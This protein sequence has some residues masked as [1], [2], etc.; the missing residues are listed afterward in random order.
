MVNEKNVDPDNIA[1]YCDLK[2]DNAFPPP[3]NFHLFSGGDNDYDNFISGEFQHVI[4]NLTLQEGWDDPCCYFAYI[5]KDMSSKDQITQIVGRVLRQPGVQHYGHVDLNTAHFYIRTDDKHVF[6]QV[7]DDVKTKISEETPEVTLT[8]Y[9]GKSSDKNS[10]KVTPRKSMKLPYVT[11]NC[12]NAVEPI[13][14]IVDLI[15][16]YRSDMQGNTVGVGSKI[17]VLQTIASNNVSQDQWIQLEHTNK[18]TARFVFKRE[19][20]KY[21]RKLENLC[22]T[23]EPKFDA[24]IEYYSRAA[25]NIIKSAHDVVKAYVD[26]SVVTQNPNHN[27]TVSEIYIDPHKEK[28]FKHSL[29]P[30]YSDFNG[31]ELDFANALDET[32][33]IWLRNPKSGCFSIPLL[34]VGDTNN[35]VPDFV[36]WTKKSIYAI[37]TK[38]A[39]LI[40]KDSTRKLLDVEKLGKGA[41]L[42]IRLVTEGEWN[43]QYNQIG[44]DGYTVWKLKNGKIQPFYTLTLKDC[45]HLCIIP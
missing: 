21:Y 9:K 19:L 44:K 5:D 38:G 4:F 28:T 6:E 12:E 41:D 20:Q 1:V 23:E 43:Q 10:N 8:V 25:E 15:T 22:P 40:A 34:D 13:M 32:K 24:L 37:D 27:M 11:V 26:Y 16:D 35:F 18:I 3:I 45:I 39:H 17:K 2:F 33:N 36:V 30:K 31:L 42:Y 29:H 7:I 14:K